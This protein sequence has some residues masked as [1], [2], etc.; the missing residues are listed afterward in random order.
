MVIFLSLFLLFAQFDFFFFF[1]NKWIPFGHVFLVLNS[2]VKSNTRILLTG[3][4]WIVLVTPMTKICQNFWS[5]FWKL[6]V[7]FISSFFLF[8]MILLPFGCVFQVNSTQQIYFNTNRFADIL[9]TH[10]NI[11]INWTRRTTKKKYVPCLRRW[12]DGDGKKLSVNVFGFVVLRWCVWCVFVYRFSCACE[13]I[14]LI[15]VMM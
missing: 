12:M 8:L 6:C 7:D 2:F 14:L 15:S 10:A 5:D 9:H 11:L 3:W 1:Q 13:D 4:Y